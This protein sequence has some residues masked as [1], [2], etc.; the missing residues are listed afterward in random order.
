MAKLGEG[1]KW[2]HKF[3]PNETP[4]GRGR[5]CHLTQLVINYQ[6]WRNFILLRHFLLLTLATLTL[7]AVDTTSPL[8]RLRRWHDWAVSSVY[9]VFPNYFAAKM[10]LCNWRY[11]LVVIF[12]SLFWFAHYSG[13]KGTGFQEITPMTANQKLWYNFCHRMPNPPK[14]FLQTFPSNIMTS[15]P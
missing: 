3:W 14:N 4:P 6:L 11:I 10:C 13:I 12:V 15:D 7:F 9:S 1:V 8:T 5:A 2:C